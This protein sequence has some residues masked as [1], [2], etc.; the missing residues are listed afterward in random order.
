MFNH[1]FSVHRLPDIATLLASGR[2]PAAWRMFGWQMHACAFNWQKL[3][4]P[5][6]LGHQIGSAVHPR[7]IPESKTQQ[8]FAWG[9]TPCIAGRASLG[10]QLRRRERVV[11]RT[12]VSG[13]NPLQREVREGSG[14]KS[15]PE[16]LNPQVQ[17]LQRGVIS[18]S[19]FIG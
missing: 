13:R 19:H 5:H 15:Y 6:L 10:L 2:S 8:S 18:S 12:I 4:E 14:H 7:K 9:P 17:P 11:I 1:G 16:I 3:T